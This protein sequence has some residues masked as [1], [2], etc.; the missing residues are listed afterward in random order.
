[1]TGQLF[2]G[3]LMRQS[4]DVVALLLDHI[5]KVNQALH[6]REDQVTTLQLR[7]IK[8]KIKK[9]HERENMDKIMTQ[10]DLLCKHVM[11]G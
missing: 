8:E 7:M 10:L 3:G 6:T 9:D 4:Y 1:M 5:T 2:Q 11:K